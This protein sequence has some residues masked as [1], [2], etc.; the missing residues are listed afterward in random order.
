MAPPFPSSR[1]LSS[2]RHSAPKQ[3][4]RVRVYFLFRLVLVAG[5]VVVKKGGAE[6]LRRAHGIGHGDRRPE[7]VLMAGFISL[8]PGLN[9]GRPI[10]DQR[11]R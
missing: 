7:L 4:R 8:S 2:V 1:A 10:L 3:P 11:P 5:L 6:A 9:G